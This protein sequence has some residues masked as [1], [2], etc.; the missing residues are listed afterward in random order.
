[1]FED[2][3]TILHPGLMVLG[4]ASIGA[5]ARAPGPAP[6]PAVAVLSMAQRDAI[7]EGFAQA[8]AYHDSLAP[9]CLV[10]AEGTTRSSP[11]ASMLR[12]LARNRQQE[13]VYDPVTCP[14][15]YAVAGGFVDPTTGRPDDPP[16]PAGHRDPVFVTI[17]TP[18]VIDNAVAPFKVQAMQG[19]GGRHGACERVQMASALSCNL[20]GAV[21]Y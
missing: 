5:C 4:V 17:W 19:T 2:T 3:L 15:T 9:R 7:R 1:M 18:Q 10:L 21:A 8:F 20:T 13:P 16:A 14:R 12:V 11:D 6:T